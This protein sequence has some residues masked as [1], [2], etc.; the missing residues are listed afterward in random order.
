MKYDCEELEFG[1]RDLFLGAFH[2]FVVCMLQLI[3][4]LEQSMITKSHCGE[5]GQANGSHF[6]VTRG[7]WLNLFDL[8]ISMKLMQVIAVFSHVT[9]T[10]A[11]VYQEQ[12]VLGLEVEVISLIGTLPLAPSPPLFLSPVIS[13]SG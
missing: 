1:R 12:S 8:F 10:S 13:L 7:F 5:K 4:L 2:P 11:F 9:K 3:T 6:T